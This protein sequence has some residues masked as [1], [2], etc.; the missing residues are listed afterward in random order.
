VAEEEEAMKASQ[1]V[2][3]YAGRGLAVWEAAALADPASLVVAPLLQVPVSSADGSLSGTILVT[4][5]VLALGEPG[6]L[7]RLP[8]TAP[9]AQAVANRMGGAL[10]PTRKIVKDAFTAATKKMQPSPMVP[11][12]GANLNQYKQHS[13]LVSQQLVMAGAEPTDMVSGIKK[14]VV[15]ARSIPQ[16]MQAIYGWIAPDGKAIQPLSTVHHSQNYVDYSHGIRFVAPVM[17][18]AGVDTPTESVYGDARLSALV[19][20]EGP[21]KVTRYPAGGVVPSTPSPPPGATPF[22]FTKILMQGLRA[23]VFYAEQKGS[24]VLA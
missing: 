14:D 12:L 6:D 3:T 7:M 18:V 17:Q 13:N 11:N 20:D 8:L 15:V 1:F 9:S 19:S 2:A 22:S 16:G 23:L 10:L 5:D 4:G 21:I 24:R